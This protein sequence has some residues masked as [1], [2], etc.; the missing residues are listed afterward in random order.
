LTMLF[1][2][3]TLWVDSSTWMNAKAFC[4]PKHIRYI[5]E[6]KKQAARWKIVKCGMKQMNG[7][8]IEDKPSDL[9]ILR[10]ILETAREAPIYTRNEVDIY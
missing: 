4:L 7:Y 6:S 3:G 1:I 8:L 5:R 9:Q 10:T 2:Y